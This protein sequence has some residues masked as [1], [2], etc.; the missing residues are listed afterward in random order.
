MS[1]SSF[2]TY[3]IKESLVFFFISFYQQPLGKSSGGSTTE[4]HVATDAL[5]NPV[6]VILA[7]GQ[8][9][10]VTV[11]ANL[12]ADL[13]PET[14]I[15]D[16]AHD[17]DKLRAQII[18]QGART[19]IKPRRN[20]K[21]VIPYDKEQYKERHL[22]ECFFQKLKRYRRIATRYDKLAKHFLAFIHI[23]CILLW[24]L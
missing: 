14:I 10:D 8:V 3:S 15:A 22:V 7:A 2:R 1:D 6:K 13:K 5:G 23:A 17:S 24:L 19:Y 9:Y 18:A 11:A 4:I 16:A 21:V 20:R 12:V